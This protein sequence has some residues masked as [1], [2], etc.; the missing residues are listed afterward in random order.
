MFINIW[1][2]K[3][4]SFDLNMRVLS[5]EPNY[6]ILFTKVQQKIN[7]HGTEN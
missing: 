6:N 2:Y 7:V 5:V 3:Q 1:A 4:K